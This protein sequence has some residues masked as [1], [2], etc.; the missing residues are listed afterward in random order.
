VR[1]FIQI[2]TFSTAFLISPIIYG[3]PSRGFALFG[4]ELL[5]DRRPNTRKQQQVSIFSVLQKSNM[6]LRWVSMLLSIW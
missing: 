3:N 1:D 6:V 2:Q 4:A 5:A